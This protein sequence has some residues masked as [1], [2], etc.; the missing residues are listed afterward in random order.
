MK[1]HL[2]FKV[3]FSFNPARRGP[4][5]IAKP[6]GKL[7]IKHLVYWKNF[8]ITFSFFRF[9]PFDFGRSE[10]QQKK[11]SAGFQVNILYMD[12]SENS[13]FYPQIIISIGFSIINHPFW[14]TPILETPIYFPQDWTSNIPFVKG[15]RR[16][17]C[18]QKMTDP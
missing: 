8:V 11:R 3:L 15:F 1:H 13:G 2:N 17:T 16:D 6:L 18:G 12:V 7:G 9:K 4:T 5:N 10:L 14:G